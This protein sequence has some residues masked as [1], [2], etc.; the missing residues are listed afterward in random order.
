MTY[1]EI[2]NAGG[3]LVSEEVVDQN[4]DGGY[5]NI[6]AQVYRIPDG[7]EFDVECQG[8]DLGDI[9]EEHEVMK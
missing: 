4:V 5:W 6:Y 2:L 9:R 7:R 8:A 1:Q 3:E